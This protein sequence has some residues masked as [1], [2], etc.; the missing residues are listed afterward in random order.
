MQLLVSSFQVSNSVSGRAPCCQEGEAQLCVFKRGKRECC[1]VT[2]GPSAHSASNSSI[3]AKLRMLSG[4]ATAFASVFVNVYAV[5][6]RSRWGSQN[7]WKFAH[8]TSGRT[9]TLRWALFWWSLD[10]GR[11]RFKFLELPIFAPNCHWS[12]IQ[13]VAKGCKM[14][15]CSLQLEPSCGLQPATESSAEIHTR[16]PCGH[17][18]SGSCPLWACIKRP[19]HDQ[20]T[21]SLVVTSEPLESLSLSVDFLQRK[22]CRNSMWIEVAEVRSPSEQ[23]SILPS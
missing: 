15:Q 23:C 13:I 3:A 19:I 4:W 20:F 17:L 16:T 22:C 18:G 11:L 12:H 10:S 5:C 14:L 6:R 2:N 8:V 1:T 7:L 21:T 9:S